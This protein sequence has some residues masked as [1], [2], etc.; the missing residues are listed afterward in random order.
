MSQAA[1]RPELAQS[2]SPSSANQ[3]GT[4]EVIFLAHSESEKKYVEQVKDRDR[5]VPC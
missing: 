1:A 2:A 5:P 4:V 3:A